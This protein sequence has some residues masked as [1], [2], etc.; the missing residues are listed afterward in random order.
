M[1]PA[2]V[3]AAVDVLADIDERSDALTVEE[4]LALRQAVEQVAA[5]CRRT[6]GMIDTQLV[7]ILESP[8]TFNGVL[9]EVSNEGKW[10]PDHGAIDA[11][12][13]RA[14]AATPEGELRSGRDAAETAVRVMRSLFVSPSTMPKTGGLEDLGLDKPDVAHFEKSGKK[15]KTTPV[16]AEAP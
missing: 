10:R 2:D 9:Y 14:A 11:A 13:I 12:V 4:G 7:S 16:V 5:A 8:R 3:L 15:I 1:S 6:I